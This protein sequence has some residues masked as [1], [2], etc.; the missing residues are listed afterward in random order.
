M[1]LLL[2]LYWLV[3]SAS[4]AAIDQL[5][6]GA[7]GIA[8]MWAMMKSLFPFANAGTQFPAIFLARVIEFVLTL[9][10]GTAVCILIYAGI[11][12]I[13][14]GE[15]KKAEA[16]KTAM[17]ALAGVVLALLADA[18]VIYVRNLLQIAIG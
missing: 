3:P 13:T 11:Q 18:I 10:G 1:D 5:G 2:F 14:G 6:Q 16:K 4:A 8:Q 9:I 7:E 17:Y 15:E 12:L